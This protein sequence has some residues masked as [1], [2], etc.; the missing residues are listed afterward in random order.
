MKKHTV[1]CVVIIP[2][3]GEYDTKVC[4]KLTKD[5][6]P[7]DTRVQI[8]MAAM[9]LVKDRF[10]IDLPYLRFQDLGGS[11]GKDDNRYDYECIL[12]P[13]EV[14]YPIAML[15]SVLVGKYIEDSKVEALYLRHL[16]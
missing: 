5:I 16:D 8:G 4:L 7:P 1:N 6:D 9:G 3:G 15:A 11:Y 10:G 13:E 14:T 2:L 12:N